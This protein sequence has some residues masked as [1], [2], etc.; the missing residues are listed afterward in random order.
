MENNEYIEFEI[1]NTDKFKDLIKLLDL[2][3][4]SKKSGDYKSDD[5]WLK[6]FPNYTLKCYYFR[7]SDSK[8]ELE[9]S[10]SNNGIWHF[11]SMVQHLVENIDIEFLEC[12]QIEDGKGRLEFSA[13]GYP[14]GGITG[15]TTFLKSFDFKALKIDE[16]GGIYNVKWKNNTEFEFIEIKDKND[17]WLR[18]IKSALGL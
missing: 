14:Y 17:S 11:Y 9:T 5:F 13:C 1:N 12:K 7:D 3:S 6:K 2:I 18:K 8:P 15:L 16:G 4:E 10:D